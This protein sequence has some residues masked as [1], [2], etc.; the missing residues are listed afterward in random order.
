MPVHIAGHPCEMD[1][2]MAIAGEHG[3]AVIEDAAHACSASFKGRPIGSAQAAGIPWAACFS[4][5]ATKTLATGEGGMVTTDSEEWA[6][7]IRVMSLH[8]ISKDAWKRYT[9]EGSWYYEIIAP[10]Y[11]YNMPDIIAA[12]GVAQLRKVDAMRR[13]RE[14]IA[15]R[16]TEVFATYAELETPTVRDQVGHAW[17]LYMLRLNRDL[18]TIGRDEF[19]QHLKRRDIGVERPF[20][21]AAHTSLLSGH[22]RVST[23]RFAGRL[24]GI[25]AGNLAADLQSDDRS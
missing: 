1:S 19:I 16:Y 22:V 24:W 3:L 8:G 6:E 2:I 25:H 18:L 14:E 12:L 4:F 9:A 23:R 11:K 10:G 15:A 17:H 7:R 5:Y 13:R 20:H 21:S